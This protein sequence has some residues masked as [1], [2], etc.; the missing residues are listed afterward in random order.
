MKY[1]DAPFCCKRLLAA[2]KDRNF[3]KESEE[4]FISIIEALEEEP[5]H[6][7]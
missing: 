3:R 6:L 2:V 7:R 1:G 4:T 5:L